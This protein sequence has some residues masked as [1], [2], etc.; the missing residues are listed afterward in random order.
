MSRALLIVLLLCAA[1]AFAQP[2]PDAR[3]LFE[4]ANEATAQGRFA[5]ARDLYRRSLDLEGNPATAFNLAVALTRTGEFVE[6]VERFDALLEGEHGRI[7]R[8]QQREVRNLRRDADRNVATLAVRLPPI[9]GLVV[10]VDGQR[11]EGTSRVDPG[12][13]LVAIESPR[14]RPLEE[15]VTLERGET[16]D[17]APTLQLRPDLTRGRLVVDAPEGGHLSVA[18]GG[19]AMDHL[20]LELEA[21]TYE[22]RL[23]GGGGER[24]RDVVV[25]AGAISRYEITPAPKRRVWLWVLAGVLVAGAAATVIGLSLGEKPPREDPVYGSIATLRFGP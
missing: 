22:L 10:R 16:H 20:D 4:Q 18:G 7:S 9:D 3:T 25:E 5:D 1:P 8:A 13:H 21:G 2:E 14:H 19:E 17:F 24:V 15:R 12:E 23:T 11:V 6:A